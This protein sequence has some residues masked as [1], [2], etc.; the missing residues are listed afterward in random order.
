MSVE[1]CVVP[2]NL[3]RA[4]RKGRVRTN[5]RKALDDRPHEV[6]GLSRYPAPQA[7]AEENH[8]GGHVSFQTAIRG[9][10]DLAAA[11]SS[12]ARPAE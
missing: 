6:R 7:N 4:R 10:R 11:V 1:Y 12:A 2:R 5:K 9:T 8:R 3:S